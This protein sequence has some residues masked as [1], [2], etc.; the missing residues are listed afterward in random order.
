MLIGWP[1]LGSDH[2]NPGP[3]AF[4]HRRLKRP[5]VVGHVPE[6]VPVLDP[7]ICR[8]SLGFP[9]LALDLLQAGFGPGARVAWIL[10]RIWFAP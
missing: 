4:V 2:D 5:V 6:E 7:R 10:S 1:E 3:E 9:D 8:G